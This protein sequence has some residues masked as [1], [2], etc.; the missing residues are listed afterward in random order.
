MPLF[1]GPLAGAYFGVVVTFRLPVA[2]ETD[3]DVEAVEA[4]E[5]DDELLD[6]PQALSA[7]SAAHAAAA[8]RHLFIRSTTLA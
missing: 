4:L 7:I 8:G 2:V 6:E 1:T 3:D 5:L